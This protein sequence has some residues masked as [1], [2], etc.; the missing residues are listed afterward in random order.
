MSRFMRA[1]ISAN[2][3]LE[4]LLKE[5]A[6]RP[7]TPDELFDQRVSFVYG[8]MMDCHPDITKDEVRKHLEKTR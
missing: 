3:E 5:A 7:M 4:R 1:E 2:L 6:S 8:Q